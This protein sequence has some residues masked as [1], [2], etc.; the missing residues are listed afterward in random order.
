MVVCWVWVQAGDRQMFDVNVRNAT[1][2]TPL[3][4][5][6]F[7]NH[8]SGVRQPTARALW[9]LC[10]HRPCVRPSVHLSVHS[11]IRPSVP[12][13]H[14]ELFGPQVKIARELVCRLADIDPKNASGNTPLI[15]AARGGCAVIHALLRPRCARSSVR[16]AI[17]CAIHCVIHCVI[18]RPR[19]ASCFLSASENSAKPPVAAMQHTLAAPFVPGRSERRSVC[20]AMR[21]PFSPP[22]SLLPPPSS[23][24]PCPLFLLVLH[25]TAAGDSLSVQLCCGMLSGAVSARRPSDRPP[26]RLAIPCQST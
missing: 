21:S 20:A 12:C 17:H 2:N 19:C 16:C 4:A 3:H 22:S 5:A 26:S 24:V 1:A 9:P 18:H 25:T 23:F 15:A 8:V 11:S 6:A 14:A 7:K 10:I 13:L